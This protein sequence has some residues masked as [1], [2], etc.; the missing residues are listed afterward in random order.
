MTGSREQSLE[1]GE[2]TGTS[3]SFL[4]SMWAELRVISADRLRSDRLRVEDGEQDFLMGWMRFERGSNMMPGF[5]P[6][7]WAL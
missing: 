3:M 7:Q 6:E 4:W 5:W 2:E 1:E